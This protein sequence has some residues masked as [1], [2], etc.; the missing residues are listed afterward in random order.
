MTWT[1]SGH[2]QIRFTL[3]L[4]CSNMVCNVLTRKFAAEVQCTLLP[5]GGEKKQL[6]MKGIFLSRKLQKP[7]SEKGQ[8]QSNAGNIR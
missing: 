8:L 7:Y 3:R 6:K 4:P 1:D 2:R 5:H